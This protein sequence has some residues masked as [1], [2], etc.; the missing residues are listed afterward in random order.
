MATVYEDWDSFKLN[1]TLEVYGI[2]SPFYN[3]DAFLD[4]T[5]C[6]ETAEEQRVHSPPAS[7]VPRLHMLYGKRLAHNNPLLP[8]ATLEENGACK[9]PHSPSSGL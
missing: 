4:P 3:R 5:E 1:D 7:L 8:S 6:M 9:D 2:L